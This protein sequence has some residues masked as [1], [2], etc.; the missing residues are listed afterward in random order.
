MKNELC[1]WDCK[2]VI[3]EVSGNFLYVW[4]YMEMY[5]KKFCNNKNSVS[6]LSGKN[7]CVSNPKMGELRLRLS[8][9]KNVRWKHPVDKNSS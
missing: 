1:N 5:E 9:G 8:L 2:I 4:N 3:I 6:F 7:K